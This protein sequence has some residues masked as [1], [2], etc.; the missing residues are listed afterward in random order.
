[1]Q[2]AEILLK[3]LPTSALENINSVD[4]G[5]IPDLNNNIDTSY[6]Y[7]LYRAGIFAGN[8]ESGEFKPADNINRCEMADIITRM[9][10]PALRSSLRSRHITAKRM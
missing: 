10:D 3:S 5:A 4:Y 2:V 6:V 9:A 7:R 1:M 8:S